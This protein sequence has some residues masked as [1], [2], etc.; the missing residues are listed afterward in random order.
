MD[1]AGEMKEVVVATA[2]EV[3]KLPGELAEGVYVV[4]TG[5][6][7]VAET[8]LALGTL[9]FAAMMTG[10]LLQKV[11]REGWKPEGW[12]GDDTA[13]SMVK[14][15]EGEG[16]TATAT[17]LAVPV[18][19]AMKTK[20]FWLMWF[21]VFGNAI[22]GV[23]VMACAKN[24]IGDVFASAFPAIITAGFIWLHCIIKCSKWWWAFCIG[25]Y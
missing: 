7:G 16:S 4:G 25:S 9:H 18:E 20:Q 15:P 3:S 14:E 1:F 17:T 12:V 10:T 19:N 5:S 24:I 21:G 23:S 13:A 2:A 11:P 22:A 8:F 6:T